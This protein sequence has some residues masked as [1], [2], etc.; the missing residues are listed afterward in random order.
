MTGW[1]NQILLVKIFQVYFQWRSI[2]SCFWVCKKIG[3]KAVFMII[4]YCYL[5]FLQC[6]IK[7]HHSNTGC[8]VQPGQFYIW[9]TFPQNFAQ[10]QNFSAIHLLKRD[11]LCR[12][13]PPFDLPIDIYFHSWN[14]CNSVVGPANYPVETLVFFVLILLVRSGDKTLDAFFDVAA[15]FHGK[16][17]QSILCVQEMDAVT[18]DCLFAF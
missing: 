13:N 18:Q 17:Q 5:Q 6:I 2:S 1:I 9:V 15:T 16:D 8:F 4:C 12:C 10:F 7:S 3:S 11:G 14:G